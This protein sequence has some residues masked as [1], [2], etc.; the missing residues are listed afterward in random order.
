M[1]TRGFINILG[2]TCQVGDYGCT[3]KMDSG[4]DV[5]AAQ[6]LLLKVFLLVGGYQVH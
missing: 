3:L 4:A 1:T 6:A 5:L 2:V